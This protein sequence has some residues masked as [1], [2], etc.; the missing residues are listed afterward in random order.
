MFD[1]DFFLTKTWMS[2]TAISRYKPRW[3]KLRISE[4]QKQVSVLFTENGKYMRLAVMKM[5]SSMTINIIGP[6]TGNLYLLYDI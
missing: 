3:I 1:I 6:A 2:G 4:M 5:S